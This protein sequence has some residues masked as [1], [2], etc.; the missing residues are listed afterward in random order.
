LFGLQRLDID[1]SAG[2]VSVRRTLTEVDGK[3]AFAEPKIAKSRRSVNL[4]A[5]VVE[6]LTQHRKRTFAAGFGGVEYVFT[7]QH[8]GPLLPRMAVTGSEGGLGGFV[9]AHHLRA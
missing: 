8:G 5:Q 7:N 9:L 6:S 2:T 1:L 4:S 3:L